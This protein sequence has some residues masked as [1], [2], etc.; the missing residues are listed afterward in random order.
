M[1]RERKHANMKKME[2][3]GSLL[4]SHL[5]FNFHFPAAVG[6]RWFSHALVIGAEFMIECDT[7]RSTCH[8]QELK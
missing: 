6:P 3:R 8:L 1:I 2:F 4:K 7:K 5:T